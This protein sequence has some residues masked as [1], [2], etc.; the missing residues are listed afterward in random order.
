MN[1][2]VHKKNTKK[3]ICIGIGGVSRSGKT[4]LAEKI[5]EFIPGSVI[6]NQDDYIPDPGDIPRINGHIDWER[7]EAIDWDRLL[8]VVKELLDSGKPVIMEGLMAFANE[9]INNLYDK[10]IFIELDKEEF[11]ARKQVDDRWGIEPQ[12]YIFHIWDSFLK[13]GALPDGE[14]NALILNGGTDFD[15]NQVMEYLNNGQL[16]NN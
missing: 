16:S 10:R 7:P 11:I 9:E 6:L 2:K 13:Y 3:P 14:T 15:L 12:W 4:F 8:T 5:T 1:Q